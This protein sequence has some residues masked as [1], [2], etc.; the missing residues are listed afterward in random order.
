MSDG[1]QMHPCCAG[2]ELV[3]VRKGDRIIEE[4]HGGRGCEFIWEIPDQSYEMIEVED[5]V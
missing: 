4:A 3:N 2:K 5:Q 1:G